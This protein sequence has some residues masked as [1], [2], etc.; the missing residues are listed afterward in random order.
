MSVININ[1][2]YKSSTRIDSKTIV[3]S[4]FI[5]NFI[6]HGTAINVL[7]TVSRDFA[8]KQQSTYTLTGPYGT[9]KSTIALFLSFLL[10]PDKNVRYQAS[11]K[12]TAKQPKLKSITDSFHLK[13]GWKIIKHVCGLESPLEGITRSVAE[14][15]SVSVEPNVKDV[16]RTI[17]N[18]AKNHDGVLLLLDEL[19]KALDYSANNNQDLYLFQELAELAQN[20]NAPIIVIGFLHQTFAEYARNKNTKTQEEWAKVQGRY[21]DIGYNPSIDESLILIGDA[22]VKPDSLDYLSDKPFLNK[23]NIVKQRLSKNEHLISDL[24]QTFPLDPFVSLLLGPISRRRFSQNERSLFGFLASHERYGLREFLEESFPDEYQLT[25]KH[26]LYSASK[27]WEYIHHNLHHVIVNSTDSK[28]WL[29]C[30]DAIERASKMPS[31]LH[32]EIVKLVAL[33]TIFGFNHQLFLTKELLVEYFTTE[34]YE[35]EEVTNSLNELVSNSILI[36]RR[37]HNAYFVFE[38][39]DIDINQ[40]VSDEID[41]IRDGVDW[42][43]VIPNNQKFLAAGN[44]HR[45]GTMRWACKYLLDSDMSKITELLDLKQT[46]DE[47]FVYFIIPIPGSE[48]HVQ[49]LIQNYPD[50]IVLGNNNLLSTLQEYAIELIALRKVQQE[51]VLILRD[52]IAHKEIESRINNTLYNIESELESV[53]SNASWQYKSE[54][55]KGNSLSLIASKIADSMFVKTPQIF[56]ELVNKGKPSATANSAIKKL[57]VALS[58][59]EDKFELGFPKD[60]FPAEKGLF[61]SCVEKFGMYV[62]SEGSYGLNLPSDDT[63]LDMF[64]HTYSIITSKDRITT[65]DEIHAL[66]SAYPYCLTKG[67]SQIWILC[68]VQIYKKQLAFF[69][70]NGLTNT[71]DFINGTDEEFAIKSLLQPSLVGVRFIEVD[72]EKTNYLEQASAALSY[73]DYETTPLV[74]AQNVVRYVS[75]LPAYTL[76]TN[77]INSVVKE[78][79][80]VC[81]RSNDP[82]QLLFKDIPEVLSKDINDITTDDIKNILDELT[83]IEK[84]ITDEFESKILSLLP[85]SIREGNV[86]SLNEIEMFTSNAKVKTLCK[87]LVEYFSSC[88]FDKRHI[89]N[90]ISLLCGKSERVWNDA[91]IALGRTTLVE[92]MDRLRNDMY[93]QELSQTD[94][95]LLRDKY[96]QQIEGINSFT[97]ELDK[98]T[99]KVILLTMLSELDKS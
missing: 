99:Q 32:Q 3:S 79:R 11:T 4:D 36:L 37:S 93:L 34:S 75:E 88:D 82:N 16:M 60:K 33:Y 87:R 65:F 78:F 67:I 69:E 8:A 68:F 28:A 26:D 29:E 84:N 81:I 10:S 58:E 86:Q 47:P 6:L 44:Y 59:N 64:L 14:Q 77:I 89:R 98:E 23:V 56:N 92:L 27:F 71:P 7:E 43:K 18:E 25:S 61:K 30:C 62:K 49:A 39:S 50:R 76:N 83:Q 45:T 51:E 66:W 97:S 57:V 63:L 95:S 94:T 42:T 19:G 17:S 40:R 12:L 72:A 5:E 35:V 73:D 9:G 90:I 31:Q 85:N 48:E 74:V 52:K 53:F 38:G 21:K 80:D 24:K 46:Y 15:L 70:F 22:I 55:V 13:K 41:K 1:Q 91:S 96:Q 2:R 54:S 20:S